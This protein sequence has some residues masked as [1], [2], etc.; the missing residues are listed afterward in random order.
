MHFFSF[1][2]YILCTPHLLINIPKSFE[3]FLVDDPKELELQY[4]Q[5]TQTHELVALVNLIGFTCHQTIRLVLYNAY[6]SKSKYECIVLKVCSDNF[7]CKVIF[8]LSLS[9]SHGYCRRIRPVCLVH[10]CL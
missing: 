4:I 7:Q 9:L 8:F 1:F 3:Y 6:S 2:K 10:V 5:T